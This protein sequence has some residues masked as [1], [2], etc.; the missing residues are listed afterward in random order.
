VA[1]YPGTPFAIP[2]YGFF[3]LKTALRELYFDG[4]LRQRGT[5]QTIHLPPDVPQRRI[6]GAILLVG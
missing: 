1:C 6:V 5:A 4:G 3:A 2:D